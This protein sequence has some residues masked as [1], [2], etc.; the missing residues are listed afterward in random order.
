MLATAE[1]PACF[2]ARVAEN[3]SLGGGGY[4]LT[5]VAEGIEVR[6]RPGEFLQSRAWP[7]HDPLLRRPLAPLDVVVQPGGTRIDLVYTTVGRGTR[8]MSGL[9]AGDA[10]SLLGPLGKG[11]SPP[12]PGPILCV[13]GGVGVAPIHHLAREAA[14]LGRREDV[15]VILGAREA[16][17]LFGAAELEKL[18][19]GLRIAT[20]KGD[21]GLKGNAIEA[22]EA[23]IAGSST[24]PAMIYGCGPERML[25]RLAQVARREAIR[26]EVSLERRMA[27]GF[28]VCY[29]CVCRAVDARTGVM[30]NVRSCLEGPVFDVSRLPADAW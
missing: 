13:A 22:L 14:D 16:K 1:R 11:Y 8:V 19:V 9:R 30:R 15:T 23:Y 17:L 21:A 6:F 27:C 4:L 3:R 20:D 5:V 25:E 10:M 24:R 7:A 29:T 28:G 2:D 12:P 18:G 26:C